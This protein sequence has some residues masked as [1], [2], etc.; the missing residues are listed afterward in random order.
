MDQA[1]AML[2]RALTERPAPDL[3]ERIFALGD[4]LADRSSAA[5]A[6]SWTHFAQSGSKVRPHNVLTP[7]PYGPVACPPSRPRAAG[8]SYSIV[9]FV[10][11]APAESSE[12]STRS[13]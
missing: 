3:R 8:G 2:N 6:G 9:A 11:V 12:L 13:G 10:I 5:E 1:E 4:A 7:C